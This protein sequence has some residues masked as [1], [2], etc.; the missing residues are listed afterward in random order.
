MEHIEVKPKGSI[1]RTDMLIESLF[2]AYNK[3][4]D[5]VISHYVIFS[6]ITIALVYT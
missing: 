3:P 6:N 4:I 1:G 2:R 5:T